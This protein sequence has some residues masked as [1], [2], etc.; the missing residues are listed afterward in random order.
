MRD[1]CEERTAVVTTRT[2]DCGSTGGCCFTRGYA[3]AS[4]AEIG[5]D[6]ERRCLDRRCYRRWRV[7]ALGIDAAAH[8]S[9]HF[10]HARFHLAARLACC[11]ATRL[12]R[13]ARGIHASAHLACDATNRL[14]HGITDS[15]HGAFGAVAQSQRA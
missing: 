8:A 15:A 1:S 3:A 4:H 5:I 11:T 12:E 14:G 9:A 2:D 7:A 10:A 6:V 13:F